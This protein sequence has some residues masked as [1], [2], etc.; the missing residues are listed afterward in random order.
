MK[1]QLQK[2]F[3]KKKNNKGFTLVELIIVIAIIAILA[4]VLAPQYIRYVEKSRVSADM[5]TASTIEK[6][7]NVL[8]AD[9]TFKDAQSVVWTCDDTGKIEVKGTPGATT[10]D[11]TDLLGKTAMPAKSN[12]A[13]NAGTVTWNVSVSGGSIAVKEDVP[14]GKTS[15][16]DWNK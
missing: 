5:D 16:T 10:A 6:S 12:A 3:A 8:C 7:I 14:S 2:F 4:A 15:Y 13:T 1:K 11:L 9:G